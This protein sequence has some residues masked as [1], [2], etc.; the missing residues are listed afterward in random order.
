MSCKTYDEL[1]RQEK[2]GLK[3]VIIIARTLAE[4]APWGQL[5]TADIAVGEEETAVL[6]GKHVFSAA[7]CAFLTRN[8]SDKQDIVGFLERHNVFSTLPTNVG[9][10]PVEDYREL[11]ADRTGYDSYQEMYDDGLRIGDGY[12]ADP[13]LDRI[14]ETRERIYMQRDGSYLWIS[15]ETTYSGVKYRVTQFNLS[16]VKDAYGEL[17]LHDE[18]S[19]KY[20]CEEFFDRLYDCCCDKS[21]IIDR[22]YADFDVVDD[23]FANKPTAYT[24]LS[25][26]TMNGLLGELGLGPQHQDK[27]QEELTK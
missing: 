1:T 22:Y 5:E 27:Q 11:V 24:G 10:M 7:D 13:V 15:N 16:D 2:I 14:K 3:K 26:Y 23:I 18:A 9:E 20:D 25:E 19:G 6:F 4:Q 17:K 8:I 12:D 21:K